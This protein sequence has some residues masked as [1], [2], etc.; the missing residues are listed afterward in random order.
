MLGLHYTPED[1]IAWQAMQSGRTVL[2]ADAAHRRGIYA[3][4]RSVIDATDVMA[5][6][7]TGVES[8]RGA[9]V[10]VRNRPV[11]FTEADLAM[12]EGSTHQAALALELADSR[13][14]RSSWPCS[15]TGPGSPGT[16]TTTWWCRSSSPSPS[17]STG[18]PVRWTCPGWAHG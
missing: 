3:Q 7:L 5:L 15:R 10:A 12:A 14:E 17:A 9:I 1:S 18:P 8:S 6:P 2:A 4:V 16:Y 11:P 13:R